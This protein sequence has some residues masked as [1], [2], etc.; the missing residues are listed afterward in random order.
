MAIW[1]I[2]VQEMVIPDLIDARRGLGRKRVCRALP[3]MV[4]WGELRIADA[5]HPASFFLGFDAR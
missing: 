1:L 3:Q 4:F 2:L 5:A